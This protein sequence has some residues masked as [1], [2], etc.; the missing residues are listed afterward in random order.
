MKIHQERRHGRRNT[1][2]RSASD[3]E[4]AVTEHLTADEG[5]VRTGLTE[6]IL[7]NLPAWTVVAMVIGL[8]YLVWATVEILAKYVGD[9]P[10]VVA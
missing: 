3:E 8:L 9:I 6:S 5:Q 10:S 2:R 1:R 4:D 7:D